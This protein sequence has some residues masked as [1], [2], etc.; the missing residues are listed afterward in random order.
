MHILLTCIQETMC[1][2]GTLSKCMGPYL[3]NRNS[4][5]VCFHLTALC[6]P[7]ADLP[8]PYSINNPTVHI[9]AQ[10]LKLIDCL[11]VPSCH[12]DQSGSKCVICPSITF[13]SMVLWQI[14]TCIYSLCKSE[15]IEKTSKELEKTVYNFVKIQ[16]FFFCNSLFLIVDILSRTRGSHHLIS[17]K[18]SWVKNVP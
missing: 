6:C 8:V 2:N 13:Y 16:C 12:Q 15:L 1:V 11:N 4:A 5:W 17:R 14:C 10:Q 18:E 9:D 7:S 3:F